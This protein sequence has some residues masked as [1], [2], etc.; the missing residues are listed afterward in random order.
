M[1][2]L[3]QKHTSLQ[4]TFTHCPHDLPVDPEGPWLSP[5]MKSDPESPPK[6]LPRGSQRGP[7]GDFVV[8]AAPRLLGVCPDSE[9]GGGQEVGGTPTKEN[10]AVGGHTHAHA[11]THPDVDGS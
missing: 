11:R 4:S 3:G 8:E 10:S 7:E 6:M 1:G 2:F 5:R 9:V